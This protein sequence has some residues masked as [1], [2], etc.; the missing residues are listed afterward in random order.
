MKK[1]YRYNEA[2]DDEFIA[3]GDIENFLAVMRERG[4]GD[5]EKLAEAV[6]DADFHPR[7]P[8][9]NGDYYYKDTGYRVWAYGEKYWHPDIDSAKERAARLSNYCD[10]VQIIEAATGK[11]L[12]GRP[13]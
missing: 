10:N 7:E 8:L 4:I 3:E 13:E 11:L 6:I 12:A 9:Q 2:A 1:F 5:E